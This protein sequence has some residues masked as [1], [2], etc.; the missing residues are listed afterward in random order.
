MTLPYQSLMAKPKLS[1]V[2]GLGIFPF[3]ISHTYNY[4]CLNL[5]LQFILGLIYLF[6]T[7]EI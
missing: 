2:Q 5:N 6:V 3:K 1:S 7:F 4:E